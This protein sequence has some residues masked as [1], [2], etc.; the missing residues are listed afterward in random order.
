MSNYTFSILHS[1]AQTPNLQ[2]QKWK[3]FRSSLSVSSCYSSCFSVTR[4]FVS[5]ALGK[6]ENVRH[7]ASLHS[8]KTRLQSEQFVASTL[9][10]VLMDQWNNR[11]CLFRSA[12]L[13]RTPETGPI[14]LS[15]LACLD[16]KNISELDRRTQTCRWDISEAKANIRADSRTLKV[17]RGVETNRHL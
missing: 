14:D 9:S 5:G 7:R 16:L 4:Q 13:T 2:E 6:G 12:T 1:E 10:A 8:R 15:F 3:H 11:P 17:N